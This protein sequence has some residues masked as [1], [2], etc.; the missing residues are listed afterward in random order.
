[1]SSSIMLTLPITGKSLNTSDSPVVAGSMPNVTG[2][3]WFV[4]VIVTFHF[5][6]E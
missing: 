5:S 1:M 4:A 2:W 3:A 6:P